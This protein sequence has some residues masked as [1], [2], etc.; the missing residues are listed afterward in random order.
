MFV[1]VETHFP[2][3]GS[4]MPVWR[5]FSEHTSREAGLRYVVF[6]FPWHSWPCPPQVCWGWQQMTTLQVWVVQ[7]FH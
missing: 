2:F 7:R 3:I 1:V 4:T 5:V 6:V